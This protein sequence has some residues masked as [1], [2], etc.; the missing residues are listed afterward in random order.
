MSPVFFMA[1]YLIL[2]YVITQHIANPLYII[3]MKYITDQWHIHYKLVYNTN[4]LTTVIE[5]TEI[6]FA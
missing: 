5:M 4:V 1:G 2:V 3:K 6:R